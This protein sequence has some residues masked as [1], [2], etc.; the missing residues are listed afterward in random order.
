MRFLPPPAPTDAPSAW[1]AGT[2][3]VVILVILF[4]PGFRTLAQPW[5]SFVVM[6]V[7]GLAVFWAVVGLTKDEYEQDRRRNFV[8]LGVAV[9]A[10]LMAV[11]AVYTNPRP[12]S[13]VKF[14][15]AEDGRADMDGKELRQWREQ[16]LQHFTGEQ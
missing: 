4:V 11:F 9:A 13:V 15:A 14:E 3:A 8:G 7:C 6:G 1:A 12:E 16:R 10:F 5:A 2:A